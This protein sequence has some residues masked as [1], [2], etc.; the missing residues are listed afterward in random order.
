MI[1]ILRNSAFVKLLWVLMGLYIFNLSADTPDPESAH[2][3][4]DLSINDQESMVEVLVES[5]LGFEDT[6]EEYEDPDGDD[7][8]KKT[9]QKVVLALH[10]PFYQGLLFDSSY[11]AENKFPDPRIVLTLGFYRLDSPPPNS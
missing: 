6:F 2:I 1:L 11:T 4:E 10:N 5:I 9:T 8:N 7:Q 3:A